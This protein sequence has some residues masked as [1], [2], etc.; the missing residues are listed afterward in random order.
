MYTA[1]SGRGLAESLGASLRQIEV[2]M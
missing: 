2:K 1:T